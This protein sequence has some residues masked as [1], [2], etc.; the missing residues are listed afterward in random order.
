MHQLPRQPPRSASAANSPRTNPLSPNNPRQEDASALT[1]QSPGEYMKGLGIDKTAG[2]PTSDGPSPDS[3]AKLNQIVQNYF[4]KAAL[5]ILH[6]RVDLPPVYTR[7]TN[8]R[9]VNKW[10]NVELDETDVL[11]ED[12]TPWRTCHFLDSRPPV[13]IIETYLDT[14]QLTNSQSLVILDDSG[15]RYDVL[16]ALSALPSRSSKRSSRDV[17]LER[18]RI[19]LGG[20]VRE[21]PPDL[22]NQLPGIYKRSIVLFRSLW[23]YTKF[24][25]AWA[26]SKHRSKARLNPALTPRYR[27]FPE[28]GDDTPVPDSLTASLYPGE[29]NPAE[30]Y[31]FGET[32]SPAGS[33]SVTVTYRT[34]CEFRV[35]DSEALLSSLFMGADDNFF[36]PSLPSQDTA[37]LGGHEVGSM[38]VDRRDD[39]Y[40]DRGQAYGSLSTFHQVGPA[41]G[42]S[43]ISALRAARDREGSSPSS[44]Q[45]VYGQAARVAM[46]SGEGNGHQRR[47]SLSRPAFKA[48]PLSASP[49]LADHPTV[50][51]TRNQSTPV[52]LLSDDKRM[53]PPSAITS[54]PRRQ[55]QIPSENAIASSTSAS[56]RPA[57]ISKYSSSFSHRRGR[58]SSGGVSKPDEDNNSSGKVS[59][60]SSTAQPSSGI[61]AEAGGSSSW[62]ADEEDLSEF[63]KV[64]DLKKD[65]FSPAGS[66]TLDTNTRR[67]AAALSRFHKMK[68]VNATL[69]ESMS[70]SMMLHKSSTSSSR[71]LANVPP[72]I[73]G[74]SISTASSPGKPISPHTPHTPAIPSRLSANSIIEYTRPDTRIQPRPISQQ[75]HESPPEEAL[76]DERTA[77]AAV[78]NAGAIDI[79][80]SPPFIPV[81]GCAE[82][83]AQ[84]RPTRAPEDE[85]GDFF[86]GAR[87]VSLGAEERSPLS[88]SALLRQQEQANGGLS[89]EP[90]Q[91]REP[92]QPTGDDTNAPRGSIESQ[93]RLPSSASLAY[94][95]RFS[96]SQGRGSLSGRPP[97]RASI[98]SSLG[99][100]N[101]LPSYLRDRDRDSGNESSVEPR[102]R[103]THRFSFN[104][105]F[106]EDEPLLFAMSDF[107]TSRR[108]LEEGRRE[109][110]TGGDSSG[111][112]RSN[113]DT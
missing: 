30:T 95:A 2:S 87:G 80:T 13:L 98:S 52:K 39:S 46:R 9:R 17:V 22:N 18:W 110:A 104:R 33:F 37:R 26:F 32:G 74:T 6:T 91:R 77:E 70:S 44:P 35:D 29:E 107:A 48:P 21:L 69:T 53:P 20:S 40:P 47:S 86:F 38:P 56:P 45:P 57:P 105:T 49:S 15:K 36:R 75:S 67:T 82:S 78:S 89:S 11:R 34:N 102:R 31:T 109:H 63:L 103:A 23:T 7:D 8:V 73:V 66:P 41:T 90:Q 5:I 65:L 79:P 14:R 81:F 27:I 111:G 96:H 24:L 1:S 51:H 43:P 10:F 3:L 100:G 76:G 112:P 99:R 50:S 59:V 92:Q 61:L 60:S 54:A 108:S 94:Q 71:Q 42:A 85:I 93:S 101:V 84:R 55:N 28:N 106:D 12:L 83:A 16:D 62:H 19:E 113:P 64:L 25:P 72:M 68:D 97:S 58:L 88:L 4:T